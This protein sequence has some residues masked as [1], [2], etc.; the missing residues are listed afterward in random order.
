MKDLEIG[1][2]SWIIYV[3][4]KCNHKDPYERES[5]EDLTMYTKERGYG[6]KRWKLKA[7]G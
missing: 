3:E 1:R 4:S 6:E 5:K 2:L 7:V